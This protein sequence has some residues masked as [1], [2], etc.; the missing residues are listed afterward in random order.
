MLENSQTHPCSVSE[1]SSPGST[2]T[3]SREKRD[4]WEDCRKGLMISMEALRVAVALLPLTATTGSLATHT[5]S[6][7]G[8][9][10]G[11][12]LASCRGQGQVRARGSLRGWDGGGGLEINAYEGGG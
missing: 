9:E 8:R 3:V 2:L 7:S 11:R 10:P 4:L 5:R 6:S 1:V 12:I